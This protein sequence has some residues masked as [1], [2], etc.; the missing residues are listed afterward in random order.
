MKKIQLESIDDEL[1]PK[2]KRGTRWFSCPGCRPTNVLAV[3]RINALLGI[4]YIAIICESRSAPCLSL[5][6]LL[7]ISLASKK[8]S[9]NEELLLNYG[10]QYWLHMLPEEVNSEG[11]KVDADVP[12]AKKPNVCGGGSTLDAKDSHVPATA[13]ARCPSVVARALTQN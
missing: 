10:E 5:V 7:I 8:I 9:K 11:K 3:S 13:A 6:F 12:T 4:P 1:V 2:R